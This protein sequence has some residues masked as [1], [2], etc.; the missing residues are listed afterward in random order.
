MLLLVALKLLNDALIW[1]DVRGESFIG[2]SLGTPQIVVDV[3]K[4][5]AVGATRIQKQP[6]HLLP[7]PVLHFLLLLAIVD[8]EEVGGRFG[9]FVYR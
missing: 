2:S 4:T 7:P 9:K 3:N 1:R 5:G 8:E 6:H